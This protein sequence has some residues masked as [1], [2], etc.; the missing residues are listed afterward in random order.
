MPSQP[1]AP[2]APPSPVGAQAYAVGWRAPINWPLWMG[3]GLVLVIVALAL[4]GPVLAPHDPM[5]PV[6]IVRDAEAGEWV[7][8]PL[9][10]GQVARY[11]LGT[12]ELG[13]D[14]WSQLLWALRPT[15]VLVLVAAAL[16]LLVGLGMG[17]ASGW[18]TG[19]L[20][21]G[22]EGV[23]TIAVSVPVLLVALCVI[24]AF[25]PEW[26]IWAFVVG[27]CLTG[28]AEV[29]RIVH[30]Q[31][32]L[33]KAQPY[34]EAA[35]ALGTSE[36]S[37][38]GRHVLPHLMPVV[39]I[40]LPFEIST[41][42]LVTAS[43]GFLGYFANAIWVPLGD[44]T[45]VRTSGSPELGQMLASGAQIALRHPWLLLAAGA[46]V[47]VVVLGFNLLGEGLRRQFDPQ[48]GRRRNRV[49]ETVAR[50][51]ITWEQVGRWRTRHSAAL[52]IGALLLLVMAS[53]L[54]LLRATGAPVAASAIQVPGSHHWAGPQHD[55]QGTY[56]AN[57]GGPQ[58]PELLWRFE[59]A[60]GFAGGPVVAADGTVYVASKGGILYALDADGG[61]R[62]QTELPAPPV[63]TPALSG[64][65]HIYVLD[66][67]GRLSA[68]GP[69]GD[70]V[71]SVEAEPGA[72]PLSG[73]VVDASGTA[74]YPT[75]RSLIAVD[76]FGEVK[77]QVGLPTYSYVS[78]QPHLSADE[79]LVLFEDILLDAATGATLLEE[80]DLILDRY[81]V[82]AD[83]NLYL[84]GQETVDQVAWSEDG[85]EVIPQARL[86]LLALNLGFRIPSVIGVTPGGRLWIYYGSSFEFVKLLWAD[87]EGNMLNVVDY[88][89]PDN[90]SVLVGVAQDGTTY[91]CGG[92]VRGSIAD[93]VTLECAAYNVDRPAAT[94]ELAVERGGRPVG[95]ALAPG[96][97]YVA[98][99]D[100]VLVAI[101]EGGES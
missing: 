82:G 24:A 65:G 93:G 48:R 42:L 29:A 4:L 51:G 21:R 70:Q 27:L 68:Y 50:A 10:P 94:W 91:A 25:G 44:W 61:V 71:W 22:L 101:G 62:W 47:F 19:S 88:P 38:V 95:G 7:K 96:R 18:V 78:P 77:W 2:A 58:A 14:T 26:G 99:E 54:V 67:E 92:I 84:G 98:T 16:R 15:L 33:I 83:G 32:R 57:A 3:A 31:T 63:D 76:S 72:M 81:L 41:A 73:P 35:Q 85:V 40:L 6:Y 23:T 28:W 53:G 1:L 86:D 12:D 59:D 87:R 36:V 20:A 5:K 30:D 46:M 66:R 100:G 60:E 8:P 75:E 55:A 79:R 43:L 34:V 97:V 11:P 45:A 89:W 39:W 74:Y 56:W 80:T 64:E 49:G 90:A 52:A 37:A 69:E 13:R 9:V 17:M